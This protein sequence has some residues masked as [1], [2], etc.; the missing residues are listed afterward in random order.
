MDL[1]DRFPYLPFE[2]DPWHDSDDLRI[3]MEL[4]IWWGE[5]CSPFE[6]FTDVVSHTNK[7]KVIQMAQKP[8]IRRELIEEKR[9]SEHFEQLTFGPKGLRLPDEEGDED[10]EQSGT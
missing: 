10:A 2:P 7:Y 6:T 8:E 4:G 1:R 9:I 5:L 3:G